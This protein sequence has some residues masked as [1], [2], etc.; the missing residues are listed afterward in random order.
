MITGLFNCCSQFHVFNFW[1]SQAV[2]KWYFNNE[3]F[4]IYGTVVNTLSSFLPSIQSQIDPLS[5][6]RVLNRLP[7]TNPHLRLLLYR[8]EDTPTLVPPQDHHGNHQEDENSRMCVY[9]SD[10][11]RQSEREEGKSPEEVVPRP[12]ST[13]TTGT[14][15]LLVG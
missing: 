7:P 3:I 10:R 14:E 2:R 13:K 4:V 15:G 6:F 9:S 12:S 11:P 8:V 1:T 5:T